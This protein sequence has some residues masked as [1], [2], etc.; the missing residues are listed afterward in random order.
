MVKTADLRIDIKKV[1][2]LLPN[3][4]AVDLLDRERYEYRLSK[5][6]KEKPTEYMQKKMVLVEALTDFKNAAELNFNS[7][8]RTF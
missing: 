4:I 3:M 8:K 1:D 5:L 2:K 6:R 7:R